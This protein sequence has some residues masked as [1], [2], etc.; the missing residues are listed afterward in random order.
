MDQPGP[1]HPALISPLIERPDLQS[2]RSR[3]MYGVLTALFWT[4][5]LYLWLPVLALLAW[6][7]GLQQAYKYMVVLGGY[8]EVLRVVGLYLLVILGLGGGLMA[9]A[10]YNILKF[11]DAGQREAALPVTPGEIGRHFGQDAGAVAAWQAG[12]R[13]LV[14]HDAG[15]R[16]ARVEELAEG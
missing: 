13:L 16:I 15:G 4:L 7:L 1:R 6:A 3:T 5:W 9:W 11:R 8:Q 12:R 2:P 10:A 14:T